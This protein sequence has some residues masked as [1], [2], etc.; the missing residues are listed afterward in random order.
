MVS[1]TPSSVHVCIDC[2]T[3]LPAQED[4]STLVS[5]KYGWRLIRRQDSFGAM[6]SEWRCPACWARYRQGAGRRH[7]T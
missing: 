1:D 4:D 3:T 7:G 6:V 2:R 5:V